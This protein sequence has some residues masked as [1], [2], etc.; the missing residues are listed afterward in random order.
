MNCA[1]EIHDSHLTSIRKQGDALEVHLRAYIHRSEGTPG[2][3]A[4]T[5]WTQAV[6]LHFTDGL[7]EGSIAE[8]PVDLD[9]GTLGIDGEYS[10][11]IIPVPLDRKGII[12]LTLEPKR[13][14]CIVIRGNHLRLEFEGVATYVEDF[15]GGTS[16]I[17]KRV[18]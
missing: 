14:N 8:W 15:R 4:G 10:S 11:N 13:G 16:H 17:S 3:D 2:V 5:G 18:V 12:H 1:I 9:G 7:V 6:T